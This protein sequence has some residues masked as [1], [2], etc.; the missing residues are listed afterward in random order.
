MAGGMKQIA[1]LGCLL[2]VF[3]CSSCEDKTEDYSGLS[4]LV[5]QRH[6]ARQSLS[7]KASDPSDSKSVMQTQEDGSGA[8]KEEL[9]SITLYTKDVDI[10]DAS[11]G[12]SLAKGIAYV[13]KEGDIV[14]IRIHKD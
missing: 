13:N 6:K 4:E 12:T 8:K 3:A 14:K 2:L 10:V 1:L 7:G 11:S 9:R 5:A